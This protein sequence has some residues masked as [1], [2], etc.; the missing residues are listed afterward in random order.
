[1]TLIPFFNEVLT[2]HYVSN[3]K[4]RGHEKQIE[5]IL[6]K[7]DLF[8][9][10]HPNGPQKSPD[11]RIHLSKSKFLDIELKSSKKSYSMDNGGLPQKDIVYIF[12]S[13]KYNE[14]TIFFGQDILTDHKRQMYYDLVKELKEVVIKHQ[15]KSG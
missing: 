4:N 2:L 11:F 10:S 12:C 14:T 3:E 9:D 6:I 15:E 8:F 1:V 13:G 7:H 5:N